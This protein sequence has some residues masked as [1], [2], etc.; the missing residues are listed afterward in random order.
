MSNRFHLS[1]SLAAL[2]SSATGQTPDPA[3]A[4]LTRQAMTG[5][6]DPARGQVLFNDDAQRCATCH[7]VDGSGSKVGPELGTIG[8]KFDRAE[9]IRS[10]LEPSA[11]VAVGY[12]LTSVTTKDGASFAG[13]IKSATPQE[14]SLMGVDG[15]LQQIRVSEIASRRADDVSLMPPG[16]GQAMGIARF[17]DLIAYLESLRTR[18]EAGEPGNPAVIPPAIRQARIER[19][20]AAPFD[21][22]TLMSWIPGKGS[23]AAL[24]LEHAGKI[25][26]VELDA[27]GQESSRRLFLDISPIVRRGGATGLLGMDFHPHFAGNRRY[28]L[29][30][31]V[32]ENGVISTVID[33]RKM[34][35][36]RD[37]DSGE[38]ARQIIKIRSVTQDHNGGAIGFGP[39][40][41]L[42][43][44]MGDTGPQ[45][46]PQGHGQDMSMLLGKL[47]RI[48]IDRSEN[49]EAYAIPADNPFIGKEGIRPEIWA[50][51]FREPYRLAWDPQTKDLWLGDVG[52]DRIEEVDI[53]RRGENYGW[54]VYEGHLPFSERYRRAGE[55]YVP[56]VLSYS[57]RHGISVTGGQV[58]RGS[59]APQLTGWYIF[60][61]NESRRIWALRQQDR[62]LQQIVEIGR[63]ESRITGFTRDPQGELQMVC[64]DN[65]WIYRLL[66]DRVDPRPLERRVVAETSER[67]PVTW[68]ITESQ[69]AE[70][71]PAGEFDDS[72]WSVAPGGF[73]SS[74]TPGGNIRT[75]WRSGDIWLR[76]E[77]DVPAD[78]ATAPGTLW[79]R[80]HHD[81]DAE[82]FLNG[83]HVLSRNGWT[84]E[85]AE[86]RLDGDPVLRPG[87][88]VLAI[89]C[90]QVGGGQYI[91]A[92]L[93]KSVAP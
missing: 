91:D 9:L 16:L 39:D 85:Y 26:E 3:L 43:F 59:K 13:V 42:Y 17:R 45:R 20:F 53:V 15:K 33:E 92:G 40:G 47:M 8:D 90:H 87:R 71:W 88:N 77:F 61:D 34:M 80:M 54:N 58:Y 5:G 21:H 56:P 27:A 64:F 83:A 44:G 41:Y 63:A 57:R 10:V 60:G 2:I 73:G 22:P 23:Q 51:G 67:S 82:V 31:Q 55:T 62:Q 74:G 28:V 78:L 35:A 79:L 11:R 48:D 84:R 18:E 30:Y 50:S 86:D 12:D 69:P 6:G 75:P 52:Q 36:D 4:D 49:G 32:V 29:K 1:L 66:L 65:G 38:A 76:R 24:V 81:E 19:M 25:W 93:L 70:E 89:H 7:T 68:H 46:D 72:S 37:E 14:L